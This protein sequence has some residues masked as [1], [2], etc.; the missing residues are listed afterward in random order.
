MSER[1]WSKVRSF[2]LE[3]WKEGVKGKEGARIISW[4]GEKG[5]ENGRE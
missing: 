4:D 2:S 5:K 1:N 3:D